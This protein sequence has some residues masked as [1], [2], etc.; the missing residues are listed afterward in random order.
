MGASKPAAS[1]RPLIP[2]CS[3]SW[4]RRHLLPVL[5]QPHST[6]LSVSLLGRWRTNSSISRGDL[7]AFTQGLAALVKAG[8]VLHRALHILGA[9]SDRAAIRG[10]SIELERK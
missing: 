8:L 4:G 9:T 5:V 7:V 10:L 1:K 6:R 2:L 3:L